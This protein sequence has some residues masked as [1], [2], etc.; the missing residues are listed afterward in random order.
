MD[1]E[2]LAF[3]SMGVRSQSTIIRTKDLTIHIDPA[4]ALAPRRYGYPPHELE[5][6][7]LVEL[8]EIIADRARE[9]DVIIITHYHYDHHDPGRLVPIEIYKGKTVYIKDPE[10]KINLSQKIR[11]RRFI[12]LIKPIARKI[13][14]ADSR[15]LSIG[16]TAIKFSK[17][18]PHGSNN[19][20]GYVVEV[21]ISDG[22]QKL[23]FSSDVEGPVLGEQVEFIL[24]EKPDMAI[25]DGP[26]T[27]MLGYRYSFESLKQSIENLRKI[28]MNGTKTIVLDH[29]LLRDLEYK[30]RI[31]EVL[32][33]ASIMGARILSAAE[34][35][36]QPLNM[37]EANRRKLYQENKC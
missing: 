7:R 32:D 27:Y 11:A 25:I 36:G 22:E 31:S 29:H 23:V 35:M 1:V 16:D 33:T 30:N 9:A 8:C 3:D 10:R 2:F 19:K 34:Y 37:L 26:M 4:A 24:A 18:V 21:S 5:L 13:E 28:I 12:N 15:T 17:P 20:L 14:I 6:R